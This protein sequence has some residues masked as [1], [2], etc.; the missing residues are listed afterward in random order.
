M[1]YSIDRIENDI[2]ILENIE[3]G[4]II[5]EKIINLPSTIS[6]GTILTLKDGYYKIDKNL[7][8]E[9]RKNIKKRFNSLIKKNWG[10]M[11]QFF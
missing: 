6:E 4:S 9:R 11:L 2:V 7:E 5:E 8:E 1:K 3:T 10:S